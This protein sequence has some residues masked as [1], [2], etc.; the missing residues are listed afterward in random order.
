MRLGAIARLLRGGSGGP[1]PAA[2]PQLPLALLRNASE[3]RAALTAYSINFLEHHAFDPHGEGLPNNYKL[4]HEK[5]YDS[6]YVFIIVF[7]ILI[8]FDNLWLHRSEEPITFGMAVLYSLFWIGC[9]ALFCVYVYFARSPEDAYQWWVGYL[10]EWMLSVD[11]LFVFQSIF[12]VM[13]TPDDQKHKP[14]FWG[15]IGAVVF[16]MAFFVVEELLVQSFAWTYFVLGLFLIYTGIKVLQTEE[17]EDIGALTDHPCVRGCMW[18]FPFVDAYAPTAKF[19]AVLSVDRRT[20]QVIIPDDWIVPNNEALGDREASSDGHRDEMSFRS[21]IED[22]ASQAS[23]AATPPAETG[24]PEVV[25]RVYA[26]RLFL[27]VVVLEATDILFAV[28]SVSAIVAQIPDLFLAY[29]ACVFAMLGLR[30]TFFVVDELVRLFFLLSYAVAG[31]L[32]F[33][34]VKL[35]LRTWIHIPSSIVCTVLISVVSLSIIASV[36]FRKIKPEDD[37]AKAEVECTASE[38]TASAAAR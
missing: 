7:I 4:I 22:D 14:L 5:D 25:H 2:P 37:A 19:F 32:V 1:A 18:C 29:T 36:V 15:I 28:D 8:V 23:V 21:A 31:V 26:T 24:K 20:N 35:M 27:V 17:D 9:A 16:R 11:N 33:L 6:W 10:L 13:G 3:Y 34:G 30:A 12:K 38:C